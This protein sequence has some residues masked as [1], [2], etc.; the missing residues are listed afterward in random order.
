MILCSCG[1][2]LQGSWK[3]CPYCGANIAKPKVKAYRVEGA[4]FYFHRNKKRIIAFKTDQFRYPKKG[5]YFLSG[6]VPM[7]YK[8][9]N[10]L[11]TR[12]RIMRIEER[13]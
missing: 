11:T 2:D 1:R 6:A 10:D 7:A 13:P 5:E 8:A 9:P 4:Q 12:Y 3:F